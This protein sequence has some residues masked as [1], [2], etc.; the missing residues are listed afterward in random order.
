M[1]GVGRECVSPKG[2]VTGAIERWGGGMVIG[3]M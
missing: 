1:I 2:G 3:E